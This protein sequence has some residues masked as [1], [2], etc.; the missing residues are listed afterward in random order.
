[1]L[2]EVKEIQFRLQPEL[3]FQDGHDPGDRRCPGGHQAGRGPGGR[4]EAWYGRGGPRPAGQVGQRQ[5][6]GPRPKQFRL[7]EVNPEFLDSIGF[8][9]LEE[10]REAVREIAQAAE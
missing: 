1:M 6:R 9:S 7:P 2:N 10:L 8:D 3:R 5:D 4:S